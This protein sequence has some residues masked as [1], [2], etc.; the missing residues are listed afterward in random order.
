MRLYLLRHATAEDHGS[1][2]DAQRALV[3]K[4]W[5][6]VKRVSEFCRARDIRP[7]IVFS[8]PLVR[9][10]ETASGFCQALDLPEPTIVPW[11]G[12]GR[13][14]TDGPEEIDA[15]R[16]YG[17]ICLVGHEPD[18]SQLAATLLGISQDRL[19]ITKASL[20][21]LD[22]VRP[23]PGRASLGFFLPNRLMT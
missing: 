16:E 11:L 8:S 23:T 7:D 13:A 19:D 6:Q 14:A 3:E 4:G 2:P 9:A 5:K 22:F 1:K 15:L 20:L 21:A 12:L 10:K 17:S 18:F